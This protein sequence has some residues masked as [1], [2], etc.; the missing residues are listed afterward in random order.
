MKENLKHIKR[1]INQRYQKY[2]VCCLSKC[3][4][5]DHNDSSNDSFHCG[6]I[7]SEAHG[8][9][10]EL[11][12][13]HSVCKSCNS[14]MSTKHMYH[15]MLYKSTNGSKYID[16]NRP[17]YQVYKIINDVLTGV[18]ISSKHNLD[19]LLG[20]VYMV[21][22]QAY[23][24]VMKIINKFNDIESDED[25][26]SNDLTNMISNNSVNGICCD[27]SG[28]IS[29]ESQHVLLDKLQNTTNNKIKQISDNEYN[30]IISQKYTT[31]LHKYE[32]VPN[33]IKL[34]E[35]D[36]IYVNTYDPN[37]N[38]ILVNAGIITS[39][40]V[41]SKNDYRNNLDNEDEQNTNHKSI[42]RYVHDMG[43]HTFQ[44]IAYEDKIKKILL[45]AW[46]NGEIKY[47]INDSMIESFSKQYAPL[48]NIKKKEMAEWS[49]R[50]L[51][52]CIKS[53]DL[54]KDYCKYVK[55]LNIKP[56]EYRKFIKLVSKIMTLNHCRGEIYF[57]YKNIC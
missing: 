25:E 36:R 38:A 46:K 47:V 52:E 22:K 34:M 33:D 10:S 9:S 2:C 28:K 43:L 27:S 29:N 35:L 19:T 41:K 4:D 31:K 1:I 26:I 12:N 15:Y 18:R 54:Y 13:I 42:S 50:R 5:N 20:M 30:R 55:M 16:K 48:Y 23:K 37:N 39:N 49:Y 6:H 11:S 21:Q 24:E 57:A 51:S 8:G 7:L 17:S 53:R 56:E 44:H 40:D 32:Y 14:K 3:H 45:N